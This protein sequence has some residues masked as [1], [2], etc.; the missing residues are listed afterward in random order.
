[1]EP[2]NSIMTKVGV[3][4]LEPWQLITLTNY[5]VTKFMGFALRLQRRQ[6]PKLE[7]GSGGHRVSTDS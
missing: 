7:V 3:P 5:V 6:L 4:N 1:M 2:T